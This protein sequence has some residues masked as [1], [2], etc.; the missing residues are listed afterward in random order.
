[1]II[2]MGLPG[3]GKSSVLSAA[4]QA[5]YRI[6]NYGTLMFEIASKKGYVSHR[7]ELRRMPQERQKEVQAEVGD[8]LSKLPGKVILDTHCSISTPE[9]FLVG[10][11]DPILRKLEVERFIYITAPI[12]EVIA[13]RQSDPT[14]IRDAESEESLS[15]HDEFNR[16]LLKQYS[17]KAGAPYSI[18]YNRQG[19]L[20]EAQNQLLSLL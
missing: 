11:P 4:Q 18:I 6:V 16:Q 12:P 7:D 13:R 5:G 15:K 3:V 19:R 2:V 14:R 17:Q 1:M 20:Q 8:Q 9:G 10:L